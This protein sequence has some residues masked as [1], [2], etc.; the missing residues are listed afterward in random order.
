M[1]IVPI[2]RVWDMG[3]STIS[4]RMIRSMAGHGVLPPVVQTATCE[5]NREYNCL[6]FNDQISVLKKA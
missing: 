5:P 4:G 2:V 3:S 6:K 1:L